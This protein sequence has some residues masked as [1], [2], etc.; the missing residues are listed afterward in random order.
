MVSGAG[1]CSKIATL[2][3]HRCA[4]WHGVPVVSDTWVGSASGLSAFGFLLGVRLQRTISQQRFTK[5]VLVTLLVVG[6]S[7]VHSGVQGW[8]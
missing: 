3:E 2:E 8:R 4:A 5:V 1:Y 6:L 7:L